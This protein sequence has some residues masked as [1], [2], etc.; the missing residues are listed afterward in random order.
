MTWRDEAQ[1]ELIDQ[2]LDDIRA[3]L[4]RIA[5]YLEVCTGLVALLVLLAVATL[6][7]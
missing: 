4:A 2:S 7:L 5:T 6:L 3:S 1:L